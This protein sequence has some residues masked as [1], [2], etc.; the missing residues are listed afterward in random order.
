MENKDEKNFIIEGGQK[1]DDVMPNR[2]GRVGKMEE[3]TE[4]GTE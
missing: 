4:R 2:V 3:M 1:E